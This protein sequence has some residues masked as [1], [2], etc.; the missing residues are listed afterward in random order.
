[1]RPVLYPETRRALARDALEGLATGD[2][3][4]AQHF[5]RPE[6][7]TP[8]WPWTDDTQMA[9]VL[10]AHL[11]TRDTVDQDKLAKA[12]ATACEPGRGY[13]VGA[14]LTLQAI[15]AGTPWPDAARDGFGG[16]GS[17]G[18]GAAMRVAPLGAYHAGD[19]ARAAEQAQAQAV[20]THAHPE[21]VAGAVAVAVAA[22]TAAYARLTGARPDLLAAA[23]Q[24]VDPATTVAKLLRK[25]RNIRNVQQAASV[26]GTGERVTA[27]DTVPYTIWVANRFLGDFT[28]G[29]EAC[30]TAG[31]DIDTTAAITG[32]ILAAH[33][34]ALPPDW[35]QAREPLPQV[36][37]RQQPEPQQ[38][39]PEN[40]QIAGR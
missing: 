9:A 34:P 36:A 24:H 16:Q 4:G 32:G 6:L 26:L 40:N 39:E 5:T 11:H 22:S 12:W 1:M 25:A 10:V 21:G 17:Y 28:A 35:V 31:G 20:V 27:Q 8:P 2:A 14:Y 13:G 18:N 37:G 19:P 23:L 7:R 3:Y 30:C 15:V 38:T 29:I 33:D